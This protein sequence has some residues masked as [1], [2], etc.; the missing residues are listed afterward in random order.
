[1]VRI[2]SQSYLISA[3]SEAE[4][5]GR[6]ADFSGETIEGFIISDR[7]I[8]VPLFFKNA[9]ILGQVYFNNVAFEKEVNFEGATINGAFS[10]SES[11]IK[12][13]FISR[14]VSVRESFNLTG[15]V[16]KKNL[17]LEGAQV[18]GFLSLNKSKIAG[19]ANFKKINVLDLQE[20]IGKIV[21]NFYFENGT[22]GEVIVENSTIEG[23]LSL[24]ATQILNSLSI[25][26]TIIKGEIKL[27]HKEIIQAKIRE[28]KKP[29]SELQST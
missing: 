24:S 9:K 28:R 7:Q 20:K 3:I 5:R 26:N 2:L 6:A 23:N 1:M 17:D 18:R 27:S 16:F 4:K 10:I 14:K 21:G 25:A 8:K 19:R 11:E 15:N 22:A 13:N 12:E 29:E